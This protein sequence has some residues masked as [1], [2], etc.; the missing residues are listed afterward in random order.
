MSWILTRSTRLSLEVSLGV[1][2]G[3]FQPASRIR[4]QSHERRPS[5]VKRFELGTVRRASDQLGVMHAIFPE[6]I[7]AQSDV[8]A[9]GL[10]HP[11]RINP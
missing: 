8:L 2:E 9:L 6:Q 3:L 1:S 11:L 10:P 7:V 4:G 5:D